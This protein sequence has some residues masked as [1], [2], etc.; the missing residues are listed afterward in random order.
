[1]TRDRGRG[2]AKE[3]F[4]QFKAVPLLATMAMI[5]A[6][7]CASQVQN[8]CAGSWSEPRQ[9]A[10]ASGSMAYVEAAQ[11]LSSGPD[12]LL[13]GAPVALWRMRNDTAVLEQESAVGLLLRG[14]GDV[15]V[16]GPPGL[17]M[18]T[19]NPPTA[20]R[21]ATDPAG[22]LHLVWQTRDAQT[23]TLWYARRTVMGWAEPEVI[24]RADLI[25]PATV[26]RLLYDRGDLLLAVPAGSRARGMQL[27]LLRRSLGVW[28]SQAIAPRHGAAYASLERVGR[29][30]VVGFVS[31]D[32]DTR[33]EDHN[34]VFATTSGDGRSWSQPVL[35]RSAGQDPGAYDVRV[36]RAGGGAAL[37]WR[38]AMRGRPLP[39]SVMAYWSQE[40][41]GGW[42]ALPGLAFPEGISAMD[43]ASGSVPH[44]MITTAASRLVHG[45]W[46]GAWLLDTLPASGMT[47]V[48]ISGDS[49]FLV[50]A[51][52]ISRPYRVPISSITVRTP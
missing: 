2:N 40:G 37:F 11:Y 39:D 27:L 42:T 24:L 16:P 47:G 30:L 6:P 12:G 21:G 43:A 26:S 15:P 18:I 17:S 48:G 7:A 9:L 33:V 20:V 34:S 50:L 31:P 10:S 45:C 44:V 1:M 13:V 52:I 23:S 14:N 41:T 35:V 8:R 49:V 25:V 32:P 3:P 4:D 28:S 29:Q 36:V 22:S 51:S 19:G 46:D 5:L 38:H